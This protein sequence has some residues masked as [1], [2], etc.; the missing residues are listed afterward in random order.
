M[1][2]AQCVRAEGALLDRVLDATH[3]VFPEG[4][5]RQACGRFHAARMRTTWGRRCLQRF[6]L[7]DGDELL[8]SA[9]QYDLTGSLDGRP[10][11]ICGLGFVFTPAPHRG[12]GHAASLVDGLA[13]HAARAGAEIALLFSH[14]GLEEDVGDRFDV[15]PSTELTLRVTESPRYGAPMTMV[16]G[17]EDRDLAAI[18]ALGRVR[19]EPFG[20]HLD[21][22]VDFVQHAIAQKRLLA[23]LSPSGTRQLH[24]LIAEEG[25]TA[26]AYVVVSVAGGVWI[27]EEC[28]D[29]DATGARVGAL[30]QAL[31]A[32]EPAERR[33][34]IHGWLPPTFLPPQITVTAAPAPSQRMLL[35]RL[36]GTAPLRLT[37]KEVLYWR[38]D[39]F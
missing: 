30:L 23:G 10:V 31:I 9:E 15:I 36:N 37:A 20:F 27:L 3:A 33:P 12:L 35:R 21:R 5:D 6:A 19:A 24:F 29:R 7:V 32:R 4:L 17:G 26:A 2:T 1:S 18:V 39:V 14:A 28:G 13:A 16:R 8:A 34:T 11:G 25:L 22:D 38:N